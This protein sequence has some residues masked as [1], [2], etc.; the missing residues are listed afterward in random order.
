MFGI[1]NS[2]HQA[3]QALVKLCRGGPYSGTY[4]I[5]G[6][7]VPGP[8]KYWTEGPVGSV[9]GISGHCATQTSGSYIP[10]LR[11]KTVRIPETT[12]LWD[13]CVYVAFWAL[14]LGLVWAYL[15]GSFGSISSEELRGALGSECRGRPPLGNSLL[16]LDITSTSKVRSESSKTL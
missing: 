9:V 3:T 11:P 5:F 6:F 14:Y 10:V 1:R 15:Q 2:K 7:C 12:G 8:Q 4:Q 16:A 13:P